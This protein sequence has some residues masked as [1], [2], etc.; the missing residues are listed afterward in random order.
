[1]NL[2]S[3]LQC[4]RKFSLFREETLEGKISYHDNSRVTCITTTS[5]ISFRNSL[6]T[7]IIDE[8]FPIQMPYSAD[9]K[10]LVTV[11]EFL[12]DSKNG[13]FDTL[14]ILFANDKKSNIPINRYFKEDK[15]KMIEISKEEYDK[16]KFNKIN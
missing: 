1:M 3:Y 6:V 12:T 16:R 8:M 2:R 14:G 10:Y 4:P 9:T 11:E 5:D 7:R 13:D 15:E